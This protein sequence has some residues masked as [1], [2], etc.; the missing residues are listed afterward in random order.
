MFQGYDDSF[1]FCMQTQKVCTFICLGLCVC[2]G[3][4]GASDLEVFQGFNDSF[5]PFGLQN[6][7]GVYTGLFW[8]L[9]VEG[10]GGVSNLEVFHNID[11]PYPFRLQTQRVCAFLFL[12]MGGLSWGWGWSEGEQRERGGFQ[13][14]C[15]RIVKAPTSSGHRL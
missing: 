14:R 2:G 1:P 5:P 7:E 4:G 3:G 13:V 6:P 8:R 9:R 12:C 15:L 11:S 10:G